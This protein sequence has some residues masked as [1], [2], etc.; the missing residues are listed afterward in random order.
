MLPNISL[1]LSTL[2][3]PFRSKTS[4]AS[5]DSAAVHESLMG[6]PVPKK[7]NIIPS[8]GLVR[9]KPFPVVSITIGDGEHRHVHATLS[10]LHR[11]PVPLHWS[12]VDCGTQH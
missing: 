12:I 1:P 4:Q 2:P 5:P 9:S 10:Q 3:S 8:D 11:P 7:S 6:V